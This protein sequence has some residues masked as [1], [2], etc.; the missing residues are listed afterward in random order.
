MGAKRGMRNLSEPIALNGRYFPD[1]ADRR[2]PSL[3]WTYS[4]HGYQVM[5]RVT[6]RCETKPLKT[7]GAVLLVLHAI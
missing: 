4:C 7:P 6:L 5:S 1:V 2:S 3:T